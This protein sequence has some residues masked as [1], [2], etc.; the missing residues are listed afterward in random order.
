MPDDG[1]NHEGAGGSDYN[2]ANGVHWGSTM[3]RRPATISE[4]LRAVDHMSV[5]DCF[6][7]SPLYDKAADVIDALAAALKDV[8]SRGCP[9]CSG[10]C[11]AANPPV[12]SCPM[13][14]IDAALAKAR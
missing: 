6:L 7:Q 9:I 2:S 3:S 13:H 1:A 12:Y 8:Q 14:I 4:R 5:E 10:D 11:G